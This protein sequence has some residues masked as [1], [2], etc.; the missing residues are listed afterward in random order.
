M[1]YR[2]LLWYFNGAV[3]LFRDQQY[4]SASTLDGNR[5]SDFL[6]KISLAVDGR[7]K[8]TGLKQLASD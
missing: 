1:S 4:K 2:P 6:P 8:A 7:M 3:L 5:S